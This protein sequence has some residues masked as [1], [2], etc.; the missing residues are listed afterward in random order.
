MHRCLRLLSTCKHK[1]VLSCLL[2]QASPLLNSSLHFPFGRFHCLCLS[3][4]IYFPPLFFVIWSLSWCLTSAAAARSDRDD[5]RL[6]RKGPKIT[7]QKGSNANCTDRRAI[8]PRCTSP[9]R[10]PQTGG[11]SE[12]LPAH[13]SSTITGGCRRTQAMFPGSEPI[14]RGPIYDCHL[15]GNMGRM[16][17]SAMKRSCK[18]KNAAAVGDDLKRFNVSVNMGYYWPRSA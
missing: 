5:W 15:W 4:I 16:C 14:K 6:I 18:H 17:G 2:F 9:S 13:E 7:E 11:T 3:A 10:V 8:P 12:S 1:V